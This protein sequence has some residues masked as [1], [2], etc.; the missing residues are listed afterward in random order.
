MRGRDGSSL[1]VAYSASPLERDGAVEGVVV[2][3]SDV[4]QR[5]RAERALRESNAILRAVFDG[6]GRVTA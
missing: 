5:R 2:T 1:T 3:F 4:T 6:Y